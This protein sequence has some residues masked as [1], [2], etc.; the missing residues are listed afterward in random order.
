MNMPS[1]TMS[2]YS[3]SFDGQSVLVTGSTKGIGLAIAKGFHRAGARVVLNGRASEAS[4]ELL[5]QF[6]AGPPVRY[7][8]GD[9]SM[10]NARRSILKQ[11]KDWT[12]QLD[13]LINNAGLQFFGGLMQSDSEQFEQTLSTNVAAIADLMKLFAEQADPSRGPS[14]V[15]IASTRASRPGVGL[16]TYSASKAAVVSLTESGAAELG[17]LG[18]RVNAVSP[19]LIERPGLR[20]DWPEGVR[21]FESSAPLG[22]IG[23]PED[24]ATASLFLCSQGAS[25]ITGQNLVVDGG[26]TLIR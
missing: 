8:G 3:A 11:A 24:I 26:I 14:I 23:R 16:A 21:S 15:N 19:G 12:G 18:V 13:H 10:A 9:L 22:R 2:D 6:D 20:I 4:S 25:W 5:D 17:P 7:M 1:E